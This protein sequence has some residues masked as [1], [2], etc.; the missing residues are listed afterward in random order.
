MTQSV[1][2]RKS[3]QV[4][5]RLIQNVTLLPGFLEKNVYFNYIFTSIQCTYEGAKFMELQK[6]HHTIS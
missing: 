1:Q 3:V 4:R 5:S 2:I 6:G